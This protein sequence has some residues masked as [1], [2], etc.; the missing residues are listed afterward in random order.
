MSFD[1]PDG[2]RGARQP[3]SNAVYRW[4]Q[5]RQM[6]KLRR[7]GGKVTGQQ[8]LVLTTVGHKSGQQRSTP[9][10]WFPGDDGSRLIVASAAGAARNPAWY[11]NI[12]A[13]PDQVTV[14]LAGHTEPVEPVQLAGAERDRAWQKITAAS[15]RFAKYQDKTDRQLPVIRLIPTTPTS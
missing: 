10:M 14:E 5:K 7:K 13:H 9:V 8:G 15:P 2:T 1:T 6:S 12:A 11:R 4:L 3:T